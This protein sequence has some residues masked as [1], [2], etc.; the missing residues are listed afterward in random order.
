MQTHI[1]Q[2]AQPSA[3]DDILMERL[4]PLSVP[5]DPSVPAIRVGVEGPDGKL[6]RVIET[7]SLVEAVRVFETLN[8]L[9]LVPRERSRAGGAAGHMRVFRAP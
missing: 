7:P 5:I 1:V 4:R 3:I 8:D 6:Y 2:H 9:G